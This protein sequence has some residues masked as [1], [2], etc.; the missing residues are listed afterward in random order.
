MGQ[1]G[2]EGTIVAPHTSMED[3]NLVRLTLKGDDGEHIF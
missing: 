3:S 2:V 1:D